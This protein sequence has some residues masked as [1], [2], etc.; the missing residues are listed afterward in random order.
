M[1]EKKNR[2]P[3][4][5]MEEC[6]HLTRLFND[7]KKILRAKFGA[8][9]TTQKR[10]EIW[11]SITD[12]INAAN[13]STARTVEEVEKKWHN[14]HMKGRGEISD[15]GRS[16]QK[17]GGGPAEKPLSALSQAVE[18]VIGEENVSICEI[19][20]AFDSSLMTFNTFNSGMEDIPSGSLRGRVVEDFQLDPQLPTYTS[21]TIIQEDVSLGTSGFQ[22]PPTSPRE[23]TT[24]TCNL[25]REKLQ[26]EIE[27]LRL[28]NA[29]LRQQLK[30]FNK[31]D[32]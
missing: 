23:T 2:K 28:R 5:T 17:T 19:S 4:W 24:V 9:V 21:Q 16:L 22:M 18:E 25:A 3:N 13:P 32:L 26:L 11:K 30:D 31:K 15:F 10:R 1:A 20:G 6:L 27:N 12:K 14:I 29:L 7:N 8:G